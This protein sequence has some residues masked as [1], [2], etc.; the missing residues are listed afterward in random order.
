MSLLHQVLAVEKDLENQKKKI[1]TETTK[2]LG[3]H[4]LFHGS[5]KTLHMFDSERSRE[6]SGQA[7][8]TQITTDVMDK[9]TYTVPFLSNHLNCLFQK[10]STNAIAKANVIVDGTTLLEDVPSLM[11]LALEREFISY[12][13]LFSTMPT[14][15]AGI[16]W[17]Q[18][19]SLPGKIFKTADPVKT[20]KIEND[21]DYRVVVKATEQ[22]PAQVK[23]V[24]IR[25]QVGEYTEIKYSGCITSA[26]KARIMAKLESFIQ[27]VKIARAKA[28]ST[29]LAE[30]KT[31]TKAIFKWLLE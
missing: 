16:K 13:N 27:A 11:L 21:I 19:E 23:E 15:Q 8:I 10:E 17:I 12:R 24:Q 1:I 7:S 6:E 26:K 14:Q 4:Y 18:D 20:Q 9:L 28:N 29:E 25:T 30:V 5:I 31:D 22:H 3:E 2:V